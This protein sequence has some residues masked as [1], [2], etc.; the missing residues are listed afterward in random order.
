M[1]LK[2]FTAIIL[3]L[4]IISF[5]QNIIGCGPGVDPYDYYV[6]FFAN[7]LAGE[8]QFQ[9]FYY[10]GYS[11]LYDDGEPASR[12]DV[13][14]KEW[15]DYFGNPVTTKNSRQF[16]ME[17]GYKDLNNLYYNID[18]GKPLSLPDSVGK[19]NV[20]SYFMKTKDL[21]A[22]GY[23]MFAKRIEPS[24]TAS[25]DDWEQGAKDSMQ[26][27]RY[28]KDAKQLHAAAKKDIFKLKYG[29]QAVRLA[30]YN[31]NYIDAIKYY[32][33]YIVPNKTNSILQP[34]SLALKAGALFRIGQNEE[35]AYIFSKVFATM[36]VYKVSNYLGFNW[37][38]E[39]EKPRESY[40]NLCKNDEEKANMLAMFHFNDPRPAVNNLQEVHTLS[41][42]N[43]ML[44]LLVTREINKL[45]ENLF[46]PQ[47]RRGED[48][49]AFY[50]SWAE[51]STDSANK[52]QENAASRLQKF[53]TDVVKENKVTEKGFYY[54]AAAYAAYMRR[55]T[56][57]AADF[58]EQAKKEKLTPELQ[59][60]LALTTL[61]LQISKKEKLDADFEKAILPSIQW[62][63][64]KA[65]YTKKPESFSNG[66]DRYQY[67]L[68]PWQ[69]YY[70]SLMGEVLAKRF[71]DQGDHVKEALCLGAADKMVN[72]SN[73]S[74]GE[75]DYWYTSGN[76][77]DYM[78][79][80]L[81]SEETEQIYDLMTVKEKTP[82]EYF[83]VNNNDMKLGQVVE[84]RGTTYI[85]DGDYNKAIDWLSKP[86]VA[87]SP[88]KI[89]K[90][91]FV[92]LLYDREERLPN[93]K[94][95]T[96]KLAFATEMKK[97]EY[98]AKTDKANEAQHLYKIALGLYN[99]TYYGYAWKLVRYYRSSTVGYFLP[100]NA[101][102]FE[103][104]YYG[105]Y[106]A[107]EAF[108]KALE[109]STDKNFKAK[110]L[111]MMAKCVQKQIQQPQ[112]ADYKE[113]DDYQAAEKT[114]FENFKDNKYFPAFV[115]EYSAT[116]FYKQAMTSCSYL[117]EFIKK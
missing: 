64:Q 41:P 19:N 42:N 7:S 20:V 52:V 21:E 100:Q 60:Q 32:D 62:L 91:P 110:C 74:I 78:R 11:F 59:D 57:Q 49:S 107:E 68:T 85:K 83:L 94:A 48:G 88:Q 112:Y 80:K 96:T 102:E 37:A 51:L 104:N 10:T 113:Y 92:E 97:L 53:L 2:I 9:P 108:R 66:Y 75:E 13:L 106:E 72:Y 67:S 111:F 29:Y 109:A 6:S 82:L 16:V 44:K 79:T 98:L 65:M 8:K 90:N 43:K 26:M 30:M 71:R 46:T 81:T 115:K 25:Y 76:G 38:V 22:L 47:F 36:D 17:Y 105:C 45:E 70:R 116:T 54:V 27:V 117:R 3:S 63:Q 14:V 86:L 73:K 114:Y 84:Y 55:E 99:T 101:T 35:S 61:L 58:L 56:T 18:K 23:L 40:L 28:I 33:E 87:K 24:V 5:P 1:N 4:G 69:I 12:E 39:K 93:D 77:V 103:K 15:A 95:T 31:E 89:E 50:Y 34:L